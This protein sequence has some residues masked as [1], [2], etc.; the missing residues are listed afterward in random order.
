M[1][2][3]WFLITADGKDGSHRVVTMNSMR[4]IR[5]LQSRSQNVEERLLP[6]EQVLEVLNHVDDAASTMSYR[7]EISQ[8]PIE[9]HLATVSVQED[10]SNG[11]LK[12]S[13]KANSMALKKLPT[14]WKIL[15]VTKH[16][17]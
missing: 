11:K 9:N 17:R 2:E 15:W 3:I 6:G 12:S 5:D 4:T 13:G 8:F 14:S 16:L 10:K 1:D 7:L